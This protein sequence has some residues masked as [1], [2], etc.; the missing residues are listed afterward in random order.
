MAAWDLSKLEGLNEPF[1]RLNQ[2]LLDCFEDEDSTIYKQM[3]RVLLLQI[4]RDCQSYMLKQNVDL[5]DFCELLK[6]EV[7]SLKR[8]LSLDFSDKLE[9]TL[10]ILQ[11]R[12]DLRDELDDQIR[13]LDS[14]NEK[15]NGDLLKRLDSIIEACSDMLEKL[16]ECI[17][18][19]GFSGGKYQ[20][21][22]GISLFFP[23]SKSAYNVSKERLSEFTFL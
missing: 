5:G 2:N 4:H 9:L 15:V 8:E 13:S 14:V 20:F 10:E 3:K 19:S 18:L 21:S 23:W 6:S 1:A 16:R 22:N 17:L 12:R 7:L 11:R